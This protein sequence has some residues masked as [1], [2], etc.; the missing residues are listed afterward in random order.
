MGTSATVADSLQEQNQSTRFQAAANNP[1]GIGWTSWVAATE[2]V[3]SHSNE[4]RRGATRWAP[5]MSG[6]EWRYRDSGS[7]QLWAVATSWV[8]ASNRDDKML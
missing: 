6:N 1:S 3:S 5:A 7:E 2:V 8:A 4:R